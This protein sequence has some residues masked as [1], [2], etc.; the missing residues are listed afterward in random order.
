MAQFKWL[1]G[2]IIIPNNFLITIKCFNKLNNSANFIEL[3][4]VR[5][6]WLG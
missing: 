1:N 3:E 5:S 2:T 6:S 4:V